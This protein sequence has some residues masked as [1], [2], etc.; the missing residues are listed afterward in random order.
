MKARE[1]LFNNDQ[2][3]RDLA[4]D[5]CQSFIVQAPAGSGKTELLIQ[6]L[7]LLLN[8]VDAPEEILA[9]TFTKKAA[10][11]MRSR[12][13]KAL[14]FAQTSEEPSAPHL[15]KTWHLAKKVLQRDEKFGWCLMN[16]P[17]QL[18]IQTIDSLCT[19]L[20]KQLPLL[21]NFGA[22]PAIAENPTQLYSETIQEVLYH[23]EENL[24]WSQAISQLLLHLDNN[25]NKLHDLLINLLSKRDQWLPY[26]Q[27]AKDDNAIRSQLE[28]HLTLVIE[29]SLRQAKSHFPTILI[30]EL[31][32]I[33]QFACSQLQMDYPYQ[34]LPDC[35]SHDKNMWVWLSQF[36]LTKSFSWRKTV[37][38]K[39]GFPAL[40]SLKNLSEKKLH[41]E[42]RARYKKLI[43]D[44]NE[45][46]SL[47]L[48]LAELFFLPA[49]A[50]DSEQW[51]ILQALLLVLKVAAAQL[52]LTFQQH[53][54]IDFIENVQAALIALGPDDHP[55]DLAL[56]LDYQ[57]KHIL[58]DEFQ[59][60]SF[61][62]YQLLQKLITGWEPN[63]GRTL[64][65][66]GDPMQSIY[67]FRE[68]EVGLFIRMQTNGIG[69]VLLQPLTLAINFRSDASIID[70]NN[71][72]FT[73]L[74]P[75]FN[76]IATGAVT[77]SPSVCHIQRD[78]DEKQIYIRG[79][80]DQSDTEQ[81]QHI[82]DVISE[83]QREK[84]DDTIAILVR[85]RSTLTSLMPALK[86]ANI[87][88]TAIDIDP[89]INRQCIQDL[90]S[91]TCAL[92]HPGDRIAWLSILR[93]PWCGFTLFDLHV[94]AGSSPYILIWERLINPA[95]I[96][97]LSDNG[98]II[99][100]RVLP[101]L[102][103]QML[104]RDRYPLRVWIENTWLALGGPAT[105]SDANDLEDAKNFF[106]LLGEYNNNRTITNLHGLR[107][108][109]ASLYATIQNEKAKI[110]IMTIHSAKGLEFDSV[111]L[112][113]LERKPSHDDKSLLLWLERP[114][115]SGQNLLLLAAIYATGSDKDA[116][117]Q[118]IQRQY[119][120]KSDYESDRVLYV[121]TT[122]A[123]KNLYLFF[124]ATQNDDGEL[125]FP[126]AS[127]LS[128][129]ENSI[130]KH[131]DSIL[132]NSLHNFS[133][134]PTNNTLRLL[135]RIHTDWQNPVQLS[136]S[137]N[138]VM[139]AQQTGFM[140]SDN[141]PRLL[142]IVIHKVLQQI[143]STSIS[144]WNNRH[145]TEKNL[146]LCQQ[147]RAAGIL[148]KQLPVMIERACTI[149]D[150]MLQDARGQ[151]ILHAHTEQQSEFSLT[152]II[153]NAPQVLV[154]DRTFVDKDTRWIIDYKTTTY[155]DT[156]LEN[157]LRN[158]QAKYLEKMQLYARAMRLQDDHPICLGLYFPAL[159]AWQQW[160]FVE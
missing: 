37:D 76:D 59:D 132:V 122:R 13:I 129:L 149:I 144:W 85:S 82:V 25:L 21:A 121:A 41:T 16:N 19:Y 102:K 116:L 112:P 143:A 49:P 44:L 40:S 111:I 106:E 74:F 152:A 160:D 153:E 5:P 134:S 75:D 45:N 88:F 17:N 125:Q 39:I 1:Q 69:N 128:K 126:P 118:Y 32:A 6:R 110:H 109:I 65:V 98:K 73:H 133:P 35:H 141:S 72:Q 158:E 14:H 81:C 2:A 84:P 93:A 55:T 146:Y 95:L 87:K 108:K 140:F 101:I 151:W 136:S 119:K 56:S 15:R 89:L 94:I 137:T 155:S 26:I 120:I 70:W 159:T 67:R 23:V 142:G 150:N 58:V 90:L 80:L 97:E 148:P 135:T 22:Q 53:G 57:I 29:E 123:K 156:D 30:A 54:Q 27:F 139:H 96:T 105:L 79:F 78:P 145:Q 24:E 63:D 91:L 124:N 103:Q 47:R 60:T 11:E 20:T 113:Y 157:F 138:I 8:Y 3:Q 66:V 131:N 61:T 147:L 71:Q 154:I 115:S 86:K 34:G 4:L 51:E 9:I 100:Q 62:Q 130:N 36:L 28:Y 99:L 92:L 33:A 42:F 107:E 77:Y 50:Y 18:R 83:Q 64:F 127:F 12:V 7:L 117:Y 10:S 38:Y 68:A 52:R 46:E 43:E 104:E 114:H 31:V 48:A